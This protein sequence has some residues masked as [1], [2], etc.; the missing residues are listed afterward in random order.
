MLKHAF[1]VFH[2]SEIE[3]HEGNPGIRL[4]GYALELIQGDPKE[5]QVR[6]VTRSLQWVLDLPQRNVAPKPEMFQK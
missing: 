4:Q 1:M 5:F 2:L 3:L 6:R